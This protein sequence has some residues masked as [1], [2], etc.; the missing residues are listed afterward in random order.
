MKICH[1]IIVWLWLIVYVIIFKLSIHYI[2][3]RLWTLLGN[4][5]KIE[6]WWCCYPRIT[7][8][9]HGYQLIQCSSD[10]DAS[11]AVGRPVPAKVPVLRPGPVHLRHLR[12]SSRV[13]AGRVR[14]GSCQV[15]HLIRQCWS[16][17]T[18]HL[19]SVILQM[20]P[21]DALSDTRP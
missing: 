1:N 12:P 2:I 8:P 5:L 17:N 13:P 21:C 9:S 16:V 15:P 3:I 14:P 7:I 19:S 6:N 10:Q 18:N 20:I 4:N 11:S